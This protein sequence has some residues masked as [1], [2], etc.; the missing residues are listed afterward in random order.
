MQNQETTLLHRWFDEVW[1]Q[2]REEAIDEMFAEDCIAH[3]L[4]D[5]HGNEIRGP[6]AFRSFYRRMRNA[7]PDVHITVEDVIKEG[8][9]IAARCLVQGTHTGDGMG[10]APTQKQVLFRGICYARVQDGQIQEGWNHFDFLELYQQLG[11]I[12]IPGG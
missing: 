6:Q 2:G 10:I 3:G 7:F 12:Q 8:D 1:N 11:V 5:E 9:Q 4:T